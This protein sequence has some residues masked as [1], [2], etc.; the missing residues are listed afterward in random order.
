[1]RAGN[2]RGPDRF[3]PPITWFGAGLLL[4]LV[5]LA[6]IRV[7]IEPGLPTIGARIAAAGAQPVWRRLLVVFVAAVG[8]EV[9]FRLLLL[10]GILGV[11]ARLGR[12]GAPI[13]GAPVVWAAN[14]LSSLAFALAHL[15][16]WGGAGSMSAGLMVAVLALNAAGGLFF[17]HAFASRGI[18]AAIW[19]HAGADCA[20]QLIGPLTG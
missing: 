12:L 5:L 7:L 19:A 20:I 2:E 8:E 6:S 10:S 16:A 15:P 18:A 3:A 1:V 14:G 13:P 11:L 4:G 17:G 9:L